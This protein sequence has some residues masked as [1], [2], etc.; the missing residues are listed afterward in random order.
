MS[1]QRESPDS[2]VQHIIDQIDGLY[3]L[4]R[5]DELIIKVQEILNTNR[6]IPNS[7]LAGDLTNTLSSDSQFMFTFLGYLANNNLQI[8]N[9]INSA[10]EKFCREFERITTNKCDISSLQLENAPKNLDAF[11]QYMDAFN[12]FIVDSVKQVLQ[13]TSSNK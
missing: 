12:K 8:F 1:D 7:K 6:S 10:L 3:K 9:I 13:S 2:D 11:R 4:Y 5:P